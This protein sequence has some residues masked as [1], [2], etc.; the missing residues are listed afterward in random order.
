MK[1]YLAIFS[2]LVTSLALTACVTGEAAASGDLTP[3]EMVTKAAMNTL[4]GMGTVFAV[5]ILISIIIS[6]FTLIP[7]IQEAFRKPSAS[8]LKEQAVDNTISQIAEKEE[9]LLQSDDTE[10]VAVIAAA[11]A[12]ASADQGVSPDGLI[13]RSIRRADKSRWVNAQA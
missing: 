8:E 2:M 5:L 10:I 13:V 4:L 12:A 7:K 3:G 1:K 9:A 6:A 11:I